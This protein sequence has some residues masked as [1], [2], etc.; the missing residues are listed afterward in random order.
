MYN[1][2]KIRSAKNF[3]KNSTLCDLFIKELSDYKIG[4]STNIHIYTPQAKN[5]SK[6][7]RICHITP[8]S[9]TEI[10]IKESHPGTLKSNYYNK[11]QKEIANL[12]Y[13]FGKNKFSGED[14]I[15]DFIKAIKNI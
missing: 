6:D 10:L 3:E 12:G 15:N 8:S 2:N 11:L 7:Y 14:E 5:T 4:L 13:S 1:M 9:N